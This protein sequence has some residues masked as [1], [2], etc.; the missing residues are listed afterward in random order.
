MDVQAQT[1][2]FLQ[3]LEAL[4]AG[5]ANL[6]PAQPAQDPTPGAAVAVQTATQNGAAAGD[7]PQEAQNGAEEGR[8]KKRN[9]WGPTAL[10]VGDAQ[11]PGEAQ[12]EP[13]KRKRK[14]RWEEPDNTT[15][16]VL[17]NIP[18]EITLSGGIKVRGAAS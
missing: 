11:T 5:T 2:A 7:A 18:K 14:S 6:E 12:A 3:D 17:A 9:R 10:P 8:R 4:Q 16:M 15:A 13:P 1:E